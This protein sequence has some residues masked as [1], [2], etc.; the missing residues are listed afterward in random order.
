[1]SCYQTDDGIRI[2]N[3]RIAQR[4]CRNKEKK[5]RYKKRIRKSIKDTNIMQRSILQVQTDNKRRRER[6]K[7]MN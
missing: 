2:V 4:P 1:L 3:K 5:D 6:R 7:K